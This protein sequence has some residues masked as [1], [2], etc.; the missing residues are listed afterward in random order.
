VNYTYF[1]YRQNI[2]AKT[3]LENYMSAFKLDYKDYEFTITLEADPLHCPIERWCILTDEDR[4]LLES[5]EMAFYSLEITSKANS[6]SCLHFIP[7]VQLPVQE[8]EQMEDL[9]IILLDEGL[10]DEILDHWELRNS[11]SLTPSWA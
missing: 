5:G 10:L 6:E 9:E 3:T 1:Y 4:D 2:Y 7:G 8:D 11:K